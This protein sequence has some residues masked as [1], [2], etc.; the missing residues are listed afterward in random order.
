VEK[1]L[2]RSPR[3][4]WAYAYLIIAPRAEYQL[5]G[6]RTIVEQENVNVKGGPRIWAGRLVLEKQ[7]THIL[8]VCDSPEQNL[9]INLALEAELRSMNAEFFLTEAMTIPGYP[10]A[11][12]EPAA[13]GGNGRASILPPKKHA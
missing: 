4:L 13:H 12:L 10:D 6:I 5:D 1:K 3:D 9:K 11:L 2:D 7:L 8:V